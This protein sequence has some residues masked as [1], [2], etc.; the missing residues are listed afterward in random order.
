MAWPPSMKQKLGPPMNNEPLSLSL[1]SSGLLGFG[2]G[3]WSLVCW[4]FVGD[5]WFS[6]FGLL[7]WWWWF[8][9]GFWILILLWILAGWQ[10][11]WLG[12]ILLWILGFNF[13]MNFRFW[14]CYGFWLGDETRILVGWVGGVTML[15]NGGGWCDWEAGQWWWVV[16]RVRVREIEIRERSILFLFYFILF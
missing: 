7:A 4:W 11:R 3:F 14:F 1:I 8:C 6:D 10:Y 2:Y 13:A 16:E 12:L 9:Y 15:L 5:W